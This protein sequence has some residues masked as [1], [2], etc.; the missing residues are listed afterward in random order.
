[1]NKTGIDWTDTKANIGLEETLYFYTRND[2]LIVNNLLNGNMDS[3]WEVAGIV[4]KDNMD[5]LREHYNGERPPFDD[6]TIAW[7]KGRIWENIDDEARAE[8]LEIAKNDIMNILH[9]MKPTKNKIT[10][11][12]VIIIDVDGFR[13]PYTKSLHHNVG[14]IVEFNHISSTSFS[15]GYEETTGR[16]EKTGFEFYRYVVSVPENGLVLDLYPLYQEKEV[17]L[18]PMKCRITNVRHDKGNE[19]CKGI[20]EMEYIEEVPVDIVEQRLRSIS[21]TGK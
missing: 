9:A 2:Y 5:V 3:L 1:M 13:R 4:I 10:L 19:K 17:L 12:R 16:E 14:D 20:V 11:Y 21:K 7:L 8:I 18:P 15:L 6:K